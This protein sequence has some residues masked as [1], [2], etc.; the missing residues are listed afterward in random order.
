MLK[1]ALTKEGEIRCDKGEF[2]LQESLPE[3]KGYTEKIFLM[4]HKSGPLTVREISNLTRISTR[5]INGVITFNI[6]AGY[7]RRIPL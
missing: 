1:Y 6:Y 3:Y 7:I 2:Y 5:S 4:L